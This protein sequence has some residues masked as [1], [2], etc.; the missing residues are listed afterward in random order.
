MGATNGIDLSPDETTLYVGEADSNKIRAFRIDGAT[1]SG[2]ATIATF[3]APQKSFDLD[4]LRTDAT[5]RIFVTQNG[6]GKIV[7]LKPDGSE[8]HPPVT[9]TGKNPSNLTFGGPD[10][11]TVFVTQRDGDFGFIESFRVD[12]PGREFCKPFSEKAC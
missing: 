9:T 7:I 8:A 5:G 12:T 4:G 2:G 6:A 1:L 11:K 3:P 10:G